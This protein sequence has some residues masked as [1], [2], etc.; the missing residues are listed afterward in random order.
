ME[1]EKW[2]KHTEFL[3]NSDDDINICNSFHVDTR[4]FH[5][6]GNS[7]ELDSIKLKT[8]FSLPDIER[9]H[10]TLNEIKTFINYC[11]EGSGGELEWREL[12]F[13]KHSQVQNFG[14]WN[15]KYLRFFKISDNIYVMHDNNE[16]FWRK[17]ILLSLKVKNNSYD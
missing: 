17:D 3:N 12:R 7:K 8:I 2:I 15:F 5:I 6:I 1:Y 4:D 10:L 11:Y 16:R 9:F 13:E 14:F